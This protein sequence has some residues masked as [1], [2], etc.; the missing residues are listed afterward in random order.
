MSW[1][2]RSSS[3]HHLHQLEQ[4][5]ARQTQ[6]RPFQQDKSFLKDGVGLALDLTQ[7]LAFVAVQEE[8]GLKSAILP[9]AALRTHAV[10]ERRD[11]GFYDYYVDLTVDDAAHPVWRLVCGENPDLAAKIATALDDVKA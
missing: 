9:I 2:R 11:N 4:E 6:G 5:L 7:R 1:L 8:G 10:G 3:K